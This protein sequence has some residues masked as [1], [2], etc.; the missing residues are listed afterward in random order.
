MIV[1]DAND[2][3]KEIEEMTIQDLMLRI[4]N[5]LLCNQREV[6]VKNIGLLQKYL[7]KSF[8]KNIHYVPDN[9][10]EKTKE[11]ISDLSEMIETL[12]L[13]D[14]DHISDYYFELKDY[15]EHYSRYTLIP[16][17]RASMNK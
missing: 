11:L 12:E 8:V 9:V 13:I 14:A 1:D 3:V 2:L 5:A 17:L 7:E 15:M 16:F 4:K 6:A 10:I